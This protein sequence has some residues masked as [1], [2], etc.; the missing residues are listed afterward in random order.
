MSTAR[1]PYLA[2]TFARAVV[3]LTVLGADGEARVL[4]RSGD[5]A[6]WF[7]FVVAGM[8]LTGI[9]LDATIQ[10]RRRRAAGGFT[11][12]AAA[13]TLPRWSI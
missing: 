2:G 12:A 11:H 5:T 1:I 7:D 3:S 4:T 8:G 6:T 10:L 13:A 9:I